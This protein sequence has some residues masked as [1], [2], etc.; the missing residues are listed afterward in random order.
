MNILKKSSIKYYLIFWKIIKISILYL[1]KAYQHFFVMNKIDFN[2]T[3]NLN[4]N[5]Y[6]SPIVMVKRLRINCNNLIYVG[7][8][9]GQEIDD[10]IKYNKSINV[11]CFEPNIKAFFYLKKKYYESNNVDMYP[12]A[13][14]SKRGKAKLWISSN[15]GQSS[16]LLEPIDHLV[17]APNV[18]FDDQYEVEINILDNFKSKIKKHSMLILDTQG[19]ELDV[20]LGAKDVIDFIDVIFIEINRGENYRGCT[21]YHELNLYLNGVG[22]HCSHIR[23]FDKWGDALYIRKLIK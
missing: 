8:H 14:S 22:F 11:I 6:F 12:I 10:F 16:S 17:V 13:L 18:T 3:F 19:T 9:E 2:K 23:W 7:A 20:L 1:I 21:Q 15:N 4:K 5:S